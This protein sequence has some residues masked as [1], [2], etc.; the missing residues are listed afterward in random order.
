MAHA[1]HPHSARGGMNLIREKVFL[2][3]FF[4][5]FI[6]VT[7]RPRNAPNTSPSLLLWVEL[8]HKYLTLNNF[9]FKIGPDLRES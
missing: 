2:R 8:S 3:N 1:P 7:E 4:R 9:H 5:D 6:S